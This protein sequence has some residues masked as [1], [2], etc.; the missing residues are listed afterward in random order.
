MWGYINMV[1]ISVGILC[2][3]LTLYQF[4]REYFQA[5]NCTYCIIM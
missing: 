3:V 4:Y 2:N 1:R 5:V